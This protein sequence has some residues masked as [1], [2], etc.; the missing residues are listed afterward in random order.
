MAASTGKDQPP[1]YT[2]QASTA[3]DS[4]APSTTST[5]K[6][7]HSTRASELS[8]DT[9]AGSY[10]TSQY[11]ELTFS[12]MVHCGDTFEPVV[13]SID[14]DYEALLDDLHK[15][16]VEP[17]MTAS[18]SMPKRRMKTYLSQMKVVW[19][20]AAKSEFVMEPGWGSMI[21]T[22]N[23]IAMLRLLKSRNGKDYIKF[24]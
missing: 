7:H 6:P 17:R 22:E 4:T 20:K 3:R 21:K 19:G 15:I 23:I 5:L 2:S 11:L 9:S 16:F 8:W 1:A 18:A 13:L 10:T 14:E 24:N 12:V